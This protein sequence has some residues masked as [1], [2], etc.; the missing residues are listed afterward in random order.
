MPR[1]VIDVEP[2]KIGTEYASQQLSALGQ[3]AERLRRRERDV[4]EPPDAHF[5]NA[6]PEHGWQKHEVKILHPNNIPGPIN[7]THHLG[8]HR[9][10]LLEGRPLSICKVAVVAFHLQ[11][12]A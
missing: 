7:A 8:K 5:R 10:H 6:L 9:V 1:V 4:K 3:V 2:K 11:Q 12:G